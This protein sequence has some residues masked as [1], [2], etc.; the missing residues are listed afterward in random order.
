MKKL[1]SK[2]KL[3]GI[4]IAQQVKAELELVVGASLDAEMGP[5]VLFGTG[6]IDIELMKDVALAGAPLD[7]AEAKALI[8]RTKAGVK[9]EGYRGKPALHEASAVKAL[10]GLSNL[11]ADAGDR[12]ASIDVNPFLINAKT[13]VAVDALIVLNNAA[14]KVARRGIELSAVALCGYNRPLRRRS[15]RA[16]RRAGLSE[17][18]GTAHA[19]EQP[20]DRRHDAGGDRSGV[21]RHVD[22]AE[23]AQRAA[24]RSDTYRLRRARP[25]ACGGA[26][27]SISTA[28]RLARSCRS[29]WRI[30]ARIVVLATLDKSAPI[31]KDTVVGIEFQGLTGIAA[32]S[33]VGGAPAAPPV[34]LDADGIPIL[35]ADL[36]E[37]QSMI[38]T[39]HSVDRIIVSNAGTVKDALLSFES[40]TASLK[41]KA[42]AMDAMIDRADDVFAGF[43]SV[44]SKV[45]GAIPGLAD[46]KAI[47][48]YEKLQALRELADTFRQKSA[49]VLEDGRRTLLDISQSAQKIDRKFDPP[50]AGAVQA[51]APR[52]PQQK[53][54]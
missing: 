19:R 34:P 29:S 39:L 30:R 17:C 48:L 38:D 36:S 25:V 6:G 35:T 13:G 14:A 41:S 10:V 43:D 46:G 4:L 11:I 21:R 15:A 3:E 18:P 1:K 12:I 53:R 2:P 49:I 24:A 51:A 42:E 44:V 31:R 40:Y 23:A 7:A 50:A 37:Q 28:S 33:L 45:E 27:R 52:R 9:I 20:G 54:P 32:I 26:D 8:A 16:R 47:E 22:A 5:V